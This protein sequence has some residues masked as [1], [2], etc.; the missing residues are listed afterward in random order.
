VAAGF[1]ATALGSTPVDAVMHAAGM[2]P[3]APR[4]MSGSLFVLWGGRYRQE[5]S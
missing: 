1:I 4:L 3:S 5:G 2:F